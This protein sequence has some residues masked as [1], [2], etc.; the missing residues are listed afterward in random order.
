MSSAIGKPLEKSENAKTTTTTNDPGRDQLL[1]DITNYL[2]EIEKKEVRNS[3]GLQL[4]C[5][6]GEYFAA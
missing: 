4:L 2:E 1:R 5:A 3:G 6:M